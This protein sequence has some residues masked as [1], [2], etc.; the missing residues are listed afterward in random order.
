MKTLAVH[1]FKGG[2]GK[3]SIATNTALALA[4]RG[5]KVCLLEMDLHGPA[6]ETIFQPEKICG[7]IND[8]LLERVSLEGFL[9]DL[10]SRFPKFPEEA[11]LY[12]GF[13]SSEPLTIQ[14]ELSKTRNEH[15]IALSR[16]MELKKKLRRSWGVDYL[17][18]DTTPGLTFAS[19]NAIATS[20]IALIISRLIPQ[21]IVGTANMMQSIQYSLKREM[22]LL[23]NVVPHELYKPGDEGIKLIQDYLAETILEDKLKVVGV[24]ECSCER[25][26]RM[27]NPL[28]LNE[29]PDHPFAQTIRDMITRIA[30][31]EE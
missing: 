7:W 31:K 10:T 17:V 18:F 11:K 30:P 8:Y 23:V 3:T 28:M 24:V 20:D 15:M 25:S 27:G 21:D 22:Y 12:V 4:E 29:E 14:E 5:H 2:T 13:A 19:I 6:L 1:S 26:M 9:C 16:L